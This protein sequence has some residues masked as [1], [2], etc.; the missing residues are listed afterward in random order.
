MS[1]NRFNRHFTSQQEI[2]DYFK[3]DLRVENG[4]LRGHYPVQE[5]IPSKYLH[6]TQDASLFSMA[7]YLLPTG[8][9]N[10]LHK[11]ESWESWQYIDGNPIEIHCIGS[12]GETWGTLLGEDL[13]VLT[14]VPP[15][16][17]MC[18]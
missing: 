18:A 17:W 13:T 11:L 6:T 10:P 3:M 7:Y 8:T 2:I 15:D 1:T 5:R 16:T 14:L 12:N 9:V 4:W